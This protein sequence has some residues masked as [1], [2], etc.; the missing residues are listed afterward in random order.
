MDKRMLTP[1]ETCESF[2]GVG[3]RKAGLPLDRMLVLAF[4]GGMFIAL[5]GAA[6]TWSSMLVTNMSIKRLIAGC[7]VPAGLAMVV[8]TG[9]ELFTGNNL[10]TI[11]LLGKRITLKGLLRNWCVVYLGNFL[12]AAFVAAC[13][14]WGGVFAGNEQVLISTAAGK[15]LPWGQ[16][17]FRGILCNVLV[18]LGVLMAAVAKDAAGK[19]VSLFFPVAA[20]IMV[21]YEHCVANMYYFTA[22]VLAGGDIS[23]A[24]II[25]N[26][27]IAVTLGNIVG[28]GLILGAGFWYA[29]RAK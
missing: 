1:S 26:N 4:F 23:L 7:V 14:V 5:A 12:G 18:S 17:F 21:G 29:Y 2:Y 25:F 19:V 8:L 13:V 22:G 6:S 11:A 24:D 27:M 20:F 16:A 28:G 15:I 10:M 9:S 3:E